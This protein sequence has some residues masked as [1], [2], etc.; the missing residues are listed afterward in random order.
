M[1]VWR[2]ADVLVDLG[3]H[4]G[5]Q[6]LA[7]ADDRE[8]DVL[9]EDLLPL[10]EQILL[11]QRH[12]EVELGL[13][14]LPVLGAEAVKRELPDAEPAAF[15]GDGIDRLGAARVALDARLARAL[16]PAAVAVHDDGDVAR[17]RRRDRGRLRACCGM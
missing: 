4:L 17:Q 14:P 11:Q 2:Q 15:L 1:F 13:G 9:V 3:Q 16:R 10:V 6:P 12:E 5:G 7:P 8:A